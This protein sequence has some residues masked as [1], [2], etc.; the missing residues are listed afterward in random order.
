MERQFFFEND[1]SVLPSLIGMY[2][3]QEKFALAY[4]LS[5]LYADEFEELS[6]FKA[7]ALEALGLTPLRAEVH[8]THGK[9]ATFE[10]L[11]WSI[12]EKYNACD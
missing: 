10:N 11:K 5:S 9:L 1:R 4:Y 2:F 12:W 3:E 8:E 6:D 7:R